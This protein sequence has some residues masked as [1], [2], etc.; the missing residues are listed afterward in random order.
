MKKILYFVITSILFVACNSDNKKQFTINGDF[1]NGHGER[2]FLA[3]LHPNKVITIDSTIINNNDKFSFTGNTESP[4]FYLLKTKDEKY[5]SLILENRKKVFIKAN[6][7][8]YPHT[9]TIEGSDDS[10]LIKKI[11]FN[12]ENTISQLDDIAKEFKQSIGKENFDE[13]KK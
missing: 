8:D 5:I 12:L 11:R 4:K 6:F 9:Y 10:R 7:N 2:I 1:K 13:I 3:E